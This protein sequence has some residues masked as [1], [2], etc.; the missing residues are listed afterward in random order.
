MHGGAARC[1][2]QRVFNSPRGTPT[3]GSRDEPATDCPAADGSSL[4][5]V[6][7]SF[8]RR[9]GVQYAI[10][11]AFADAEELGQVTGLVLAT[12]TEALEWQAAAIWGLDED[13]ATL[14]SVDVHPSTGPLDPWATATRELRLAMGEGVPGSVWATGR[15]VWIRDTGDQAGFARRDAARRVGLGHGF[16]FPVRV[17]GEVRAVVELFAAGVRSLDAEQAEFLETVGLQMGSFLERIDARHAVAESEARKSGILRAAVDAIV[18]A[19]ATGRI[20]EFNDAA[21]R[22]LGCRRRDV[23]GKTI[24]EIL[25]PPDLRDAHQAGL[26]RYVATGEPTIMGQRVRTRAARGDGTTVPVELTVTE[27]R[28]AGRPM[29][30]AFIRDISREREAETVRDRFL[31]ILSHELR[32]PLTAI[33]GGAKLLCRRSLDPASREELIDD[34]GVEAE[35]LHRLVQNLIVLAR[36]ER[37]ANVM[38]L[39]PLHLDR[40]VERVVDAARA[41]WPIEITLTSHGSRRAV[42]GDETSVEQLLANLLSNAAKYAAGGGVVDVEID[43]GVAST[44]VRVLDRGPGVDA[45]DASRLFEID[46][47]SPLMELLAQGSGIG[48][49]VA[50]WLVEAMGGRIWLAPRPGGGSEFGFALQ[51]VS[52]DLGAPGAGAPPT[53]LGLHLD[54]VADA[55]AG[56]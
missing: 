17:R 35:R 45:A 40:I 55:A 34:I 12:L 44:T 53:V 43:H 15:P 24:G 54:D 38:A 51:V 32:T 21:E 50:R 19:D 16:A 22:L 46:Y 13:G 33:Y 3:L 26:A 1:V 8:E 31:E 28:L 48:L 14:R 7:L 4:S 52:D 18:S 23:I 25:V 39:E 9:L 11:R 49:F 41:Q 29:F 27:V 10:S 56:R 5:A 37:G 36:A 6:T 2:L 42:Q 20:L 30:T 47:R